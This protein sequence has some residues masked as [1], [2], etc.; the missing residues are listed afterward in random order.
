MPSAYTVSASSDF[1]AK[2]FQIAPGSSA[3]EL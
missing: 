2:R 3:L 1:A